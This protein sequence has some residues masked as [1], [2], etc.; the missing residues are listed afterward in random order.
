VLTA[1]QIADVIFDFDMETGA[2]SS[3][4]MSLQ[5][6]GSPASPGELADLSG[7]RAH[8]SARRLICPL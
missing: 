5:D 7:H 2:A 4:I 6:P 1:G 3:A 8:K